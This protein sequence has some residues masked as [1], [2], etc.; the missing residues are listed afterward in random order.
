MFKTLYLKYLHVTVFS[1]YEI[2]QEK[3]NFKLYL[4]RRPKDHRRFLMMMTYTGNF[5][6]VPPPQIRNMRNDKP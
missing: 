2:K 4:N 5:N 3:N 6:T 1:S